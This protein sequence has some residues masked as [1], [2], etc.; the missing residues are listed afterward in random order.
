VLRKY[1]LLFFINKEA[2]V[3]KVLLTAMLI[4]SLFII[5]GGYL[6]IQRCAERL[7]GIGNSSGLSEIEAPNHN[8][9]NGRHWRQADRDVK[10]HS[11]A[12]SASQ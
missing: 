4:L 6:H 5:G 8:I 1:E 11:M 9:K 7:D 12:T 10:E 3:K 2:C